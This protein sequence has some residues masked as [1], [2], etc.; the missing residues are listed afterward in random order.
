MKCIQLQLRRAKN[1]ILSSFSDP[2]GAVCI[3]VGTIAFGM[4]LDAANVRNIIHWGPSDSIESYIQETGRAGRD[5]LESIA[6]LY[7]EKSKSSRASDMMKAYC[8]NTS[9]CRRK[10]LIK[11]F[12]RNDIECPEISHSCCDICAQHC[13]CDEVC[14]EAVHVPPSVSNNSEHQQKRLRAP[15]K[16]QKEI[17]QSALHEYRN[18]LCSL[19]I[20]KP[21]PLLF[22]KETISG[23]PDSLPNVPTCITWLTL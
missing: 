13:D 6:L 21:V 16:A 19:D 8:S 5:G 18:T 12:S 4:G 11:E 15:S 3:I 23:I 17:V 9:V 10:F 1:Y 14:K 20:N 7:Y 22:G 2:D